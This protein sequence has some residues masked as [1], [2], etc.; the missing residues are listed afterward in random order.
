MLF[1]NTII[2]ICPFNSFSIKI[3]KIK[4]F[5]ILCFSFLFKK[6][7][8]YLTSNYLNFDLKSYDDS[9]EFL[10]WSFTPYKSLI[11]EVLTLIGIPKDRTRLRYPNLKFCLEYQRTT[12]LQYPNLKFTIKNI[13]N[14][15]YIKFSKLKKILNISTTEFSQRTT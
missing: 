2:D 7:M 12:R 4:N 1:F 10:K 9:I 11:Q 3:K 8:F 6:K 13:Q 14:K 15:K 5:D